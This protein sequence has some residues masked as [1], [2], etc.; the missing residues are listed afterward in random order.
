MKNSLSR[1]LIVIVMSA[2]VFGTVAIHRTN[3]YVLLGSAQI[4]KLCWSGSGDKRTVSW[5]IKGDA[6]AILRESLMYATNSWSHASKF[7]IEFIEGPSGISIE[8]DSVGTHFKDPVTLAVTS[9][10]SDATGRIQQASIIVNA[11]GFD[12]KRNDVRGVGPRRSGKKRSVDLDAVILHELG[13]AIGI[14]HSDLTPTAI[15]GD[16]SYNQLPTMNSVIYAGAETL[17]ADDE[18]AVQ[19]LYGQATLDPADQVAVTASP[20]TGKKPLNV[21]FDALGAPADSYWDYGDGSVGTNRVHKY[22]V[23]GI[24]AVK[25]YFN[26]FVGTTYVEVTKKAKKAKKRSDKATQQP[27][28]GNP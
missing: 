27:D 2:F 12:Y 21:S 17:H 10:V 5:H 26:G 28:L 1:A 9:A 11:A 24:Y 16:C 18:A 23:P 3:A 15:V 14:S 7:Q 25:V 22:T 8:W 13:H 6:P 4:P 19:A 20:N